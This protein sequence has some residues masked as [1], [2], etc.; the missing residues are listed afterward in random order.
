MLRTAILLCLVVLSG[1]TGSLKPNSET[2]LDTPLT[3]RD[4]NDVSDQYSARPTFVSLVERYQT[5]MMLSIKVDMFGTD[6]HLYIPEQAVPEL[7]PFIDK[8]FEWEKLAS[9]RG[10]Q[11]DKEIGT[12]QGWGA[13]KLKAHF[14][15][16]NV[17]RHFLAIRQCALG[18]F[19]G[20][21]DEEFYFDR[22]E[23]KVLRELMVDLRDGNL[24]MLN[25]DEVYN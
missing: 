17:D 7:L 16:G 2:R 8:Y 9:S 14:F 21:G 6:S 23:A 13:F 20:E 10:D 24:K 12:A 1:C 15:S 11:L 5:G 4:F 22:E 3:V 19:G 18:C 25:T